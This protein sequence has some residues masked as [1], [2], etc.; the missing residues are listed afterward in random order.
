MTG[1]L[2]SRG[3]SDCAYRAQFELELAAKE[4]N[5][6][7]GLVM[8][9]KKCFNNIRWVIGFNLL[10]D[11]GVPIQILRIWIHSIA[12][13]SRYWVL[14]GDYFYAGFSTGG[15]PEGDSWSVIVMV[16]LAAAWVSFLEHT[17]PARSQP[18]LSA[19]ADN[20]SWT[21]QEMLGHH[22]AM[23][24]TCRLITLAGYF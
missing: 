23:T 6:C 18:C 20:W 10:L 12:N 7:S 4:R 21:L 22:I 17:I 15:F 11:I 14:Q 19:Y 3:A 9:L 16:A 5:R 13:L 8:D 2:P 24:N 1:L